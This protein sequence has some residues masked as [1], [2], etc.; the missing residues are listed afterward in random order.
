[1]LAPLMKQS[2]KLI[3]ANIKKFVGVLWPAIGLLNFRPKLFEDLTRKARVAPIKTDNKEFLVLI[4]EK[5]CKTQQ[6]FNAA[7]AA[8]M[9]HIFEFSSEFALV[10]N[11]NIV[12]CFIVTIK[13]GERDFGV[14]G[15]S[16]GVQA[17][18]IGLVAIDFEEG[19]KDSFFGFLVAAILFHLSIR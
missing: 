16:A 11:K 1:M 7:F 3:E 12:N 17:G 15:Q 18:E 2:V 4:N 8:T 5:Q 13:G 10:E 19:R 6:M 9:D 14:F